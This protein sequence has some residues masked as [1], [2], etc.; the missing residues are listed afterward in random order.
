LPK[1]RVAEPLDVVGLAMALLKTCHPPPGFRVRTTAE[2][3]GPGLGVQK[4]ELRGGSS[5][6]ESRD[7]AVSRT[8]GWLPTEEERV[9]DEE[10]GGVT[11]IPRRKRPG[12]VR[13][14]PLLRYLQRGYWAISSILVCSLQRFTRRSAYLF[15]LPKHPFSNRSDSHSTVASVADFTKNHAARWRSTRVYI[16]VWEASPF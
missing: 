16:G 12:P 7:K 13:L 10:R 14:R 8:V 9:N 6:R 3:R 5:G 2:Y 15:R 11:P 1:A 4:L